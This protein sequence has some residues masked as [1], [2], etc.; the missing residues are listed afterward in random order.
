[1]VYCWIH[2]RRSTSTAGI[3]RSQ[4]GAAVG[5]GAEDAKAVGA[6]LRSEL[7]PLG[8]VVG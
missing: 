3:S 6:D 7:V 8:H 2:T 5:H 1:M 4:L